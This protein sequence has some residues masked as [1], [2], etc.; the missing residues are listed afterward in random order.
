MATLRE[1]AAEM[2]AI[3]FPAIFVG[4]FTFRNDDGSVFTG[5]E[6]SGNIV[7]SVC[8]FTCGFVSFTK[9]YLLY[10]DCRQD[11]RHSGLIIILTHL[12]FHLYR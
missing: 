11:Y 7:G 4:L 5:Q 2:F 3:S 12:P 10:F 8:E 9:D 1:I 6:L